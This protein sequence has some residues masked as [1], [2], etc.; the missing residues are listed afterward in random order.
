M[1]FHSTFKHLFA[2]IW[3]CFFLQGPHLWTGFNRSEYAFK[4]SAK[5]FGHGPRFL[6]ILSE[7]VGGF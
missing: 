7:F 5:R 2:D 4:R 6:V 3:T 1:D